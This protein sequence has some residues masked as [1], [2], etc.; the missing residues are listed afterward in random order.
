MLKS[1]RHPRGTCAAS[2]K[3]MRRS[4]RAFTLIELLVVIAIISLLIAIL[5]PSLAA[6]RRSAQRAKCAANLKSIAFAWQAYLQDNDDHFLQGTP[7]DTTQFNY[8]GKFGALPPFQKSKPLNSYLQLDREALTDAP[9]F[10]CPSDQGGPNTPGRF[11]DFFGTSYAPNLML[12]GDL[13]LDPGGFAPPLAP[14]VQEMN[15]ELAGLTGT[16][17]FDHSRLVLMGDFGWIFDWNYHDTINKAQ[18]HH[19]P[20]THNLAF[21]DGHVNFTQIRK[22]LQ[23]TQDYVVF[24]LAEFV[25]RAVELQVEAP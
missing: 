23:V 6:A 14:L 20:R 5:L 2:A 18:W 7:G 9:V 21:M 4:A 25:D 13:P 10:E 12:V 3:S 15:P 11:Y 24:P 1:I 17:A 16:R 8:G 19:R 22:G